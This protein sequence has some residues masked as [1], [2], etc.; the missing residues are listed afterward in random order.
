M[1]AMQR[2]GVIVLASS[3][4]GII[5]VNTLVDAWGNG[6]FTS[7]LAVWFIMA[8]FALWLHGDIGG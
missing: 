1:R 8:A 5:A 4:I 7:M 2:K 3:G 6:E